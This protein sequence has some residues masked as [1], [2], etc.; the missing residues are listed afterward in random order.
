[1]GKVYEYLRLRQFGATS[2][3]AL[4][5]RAAGANGISRQECR[6]LM[7]PAAVW[8]N[9]EFRPSLS[10]IP[11]QLRISCRRTTCDRR[12]LHEVAPSSFGKASYDNTL[13]L[14]V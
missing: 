7:S 1:M 8:R 3:V 13:L 14:A 9:G 2:Q 12:L 11:S 4:V 6:A 5:G 10:R